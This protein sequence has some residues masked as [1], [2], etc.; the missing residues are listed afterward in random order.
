MAAAFTEQEKNSIRAAL[1]KSAQECIPTVGV[2]GATVE[3]LTKSA[4]IS[5]GAFYDFYESKE[6]LFFEVME[7]W[8][9]VLYSEAMKVLR[10]RTDLSDSDRAAEALLRVCEILE[11]NMLMDFLENDLPYI[12]R[13]IPPQVLQRHYH[14]DDVHIG[15]ILRKSGLHLT[16]PPEVACEAVRLLFLSLTNR[17]Q[18]G[19]YFPQVLELTV[20]SVCSRLISN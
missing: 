3:H 2:R 14:S 20:R 6:H 18:I 7:D 16:Q 17:R 11:K 19:K 1:K 13:K 8:H 9:E 10:E 15:E 12:L 5:K 4:G